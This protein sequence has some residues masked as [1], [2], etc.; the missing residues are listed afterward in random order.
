M[1]KVCVGG[2]KKT[3]NYLKVWRNLNEYLN[4]LM[5]IQIELPE[6][7]PSTAGT[8]CGGCQQ[9]PHQNVTNYFK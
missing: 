4:L 6:V 7:C 1:W 3:E 9:I 2:I 8:E 5:L